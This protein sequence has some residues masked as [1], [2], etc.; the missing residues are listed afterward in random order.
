MR[1]QDKAKIHRECVGITLKRKSG[2]EKRTGNR[3]V[4]AVARKSSSGCTGTASGV[5]KWGERVQPIG[6]KKGDR[7]SEER[8]LPWT[9]EKSE[10]AN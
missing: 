1:K 7:P 3:E 8:G 9:C 2:T 4:S 10:R 6:G 5:K